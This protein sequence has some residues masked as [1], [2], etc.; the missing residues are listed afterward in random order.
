MAVDVQIGL[1]KG[2]GLARRDTQLQFDEIK[3]GD[4]LG[5]GVFNLQAGVHLHE[6]KAAVAQI[7]LGDELDRAGT[8]VADRL[9]RLDGS[10]AHRGAKGVSHA[11]GGGFLD[12]LLVAALQRTV[13]F[14]KVDD[15]AMVVAKDL[16][17][18]MAGVGD[19]AFDQH[20]GIA[21]AGKGLA[22]GTLQSG[23]EI[24]RTLHQTH[25]L[26]ATASTGLDQHGIADLRRLIRQKRAVLTRTVI[27]R[28]HRHARAFHQRLGRVFQPHGPDRIGAGP[29]KDQTGRRDRIDEIGVLGQKA[30]ARMH[31]L[32]ASGQRRADDDIAL[33]IAFGHGCGADPHRLVGHLDM[34]RLC[35]GIGMHC[36]RAN[37]HPSG[38]GDD[39]TCDFA[40]IGD[41]D[42]GEH[43]APLTSER[44]QSVSAG[45]ARSVRRTATGPTRRG[46]CADR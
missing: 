35:I 17:L 38:R 11:G 37:A 19:I 16:H 10:L 13:T 40:A 3:S 2:Q 29:D 39:P 46:F 20:G 36:H 25:P 1:G 6:P 9:G 45:S 5:H 33:Q 41:Q 28:H 43:H 8:R 21:K 34:Q 7:A 22:L 32:R 4:R 42:F 26:A 23:G 14:E 30:I 44:R 27:A 12:H 18:D 31:G 15:M 24:G